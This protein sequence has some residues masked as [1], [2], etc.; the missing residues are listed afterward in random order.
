MILTL[1]IGGVDRTE[2]L[3]VETLKPSSQLGSRGT[4]T[5][6]LRSPVSGE[7]PVYRPAIGAVVEVENVATSA[8]IFAGTIDGIDEGLYADIDSDRAVMEY[9]VSAVDYNQIADRHLVNDAY[10]GM[11]AGDIVKVI[12][13]DFFTDDGISE[14]VTTNHVEDGV[15]ISKAVF[16]YVSAAQAFDDLCDQTGFSWWIDEDLDLHFCDRSSV[17]APFSL[18]SSSANWRGMRVSRT[19]EDYRNKQFVRAGK[20]LSD[21]RTERFAGDGETKTYTTAYPL[22]TAPSVTVNGAPKTVGIGGVDSGEDWYWN[23]ESNTIS[24]DSEGTALSSSDV[25]AVTYRGLIP[26]VVEIQDDIE[27]A[28]RRSIEGGTGIYEA[29]ASAPEIDDRGMAEDKARAYLRK[30]GVIPQTVTFETDA[31]GLRAGQLLSINVPVHGISGGDYLIESVSLRDVG[32]KMFRYSVKALSGESLGGWLKW[33]AKLANA[34]QIH[35]IRENETVNKLRSFRDGVVCSDSFSIG[36]ET[37]E[38][39]IGYGTIGFM[40]IG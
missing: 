4:C 20:Y 24:Q 28:A 2:Y 34:A 23:K 10:E 17:A 1:T 3:R 31:D 18:T 11:L 15:T 21:A 33:F 38:T 30:Y 5:F 36:T 27:I 7:V 8:I 16:S 19:R 12:V 26:L 13:A 29:V 25:L 39:R 32:G 37:P 22:G 14:N 9:R 6:S 40:V 35:T